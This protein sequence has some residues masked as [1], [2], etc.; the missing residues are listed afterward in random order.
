MQYEGKN[1][2]RIK[3]SF[4]YPDGTP[5]L[6]CSAQSV[7]VEGVDAI[8]EFYD[9]VRDS[10]LDFCE[11]WLIKIC[12]PPNEYSYRLV[13][14]VAQGQEKM[15]VTLRRRLPTERKEGCYPLHR[16][17]TSG[18]A[19]DICEGCSGRKSIKFSDFRRQV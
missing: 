1:D 5:C 8:G 16:I 7:R 3:R 6:I 15:T 11:Q 10:A 19:R 18:T 4:N 9:K 12:A 14:K 2:L 13:C 17:L